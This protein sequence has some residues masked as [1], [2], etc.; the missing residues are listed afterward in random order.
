LVR[1]NDINTTI[2]LVE[3]GTRPARVP[4]IIDAPTPAHHAAQRLATSFGHSESS[5]PM[6]PPMTGLTL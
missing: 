5:W 6:G 3:S 1:S 2:V 4:E